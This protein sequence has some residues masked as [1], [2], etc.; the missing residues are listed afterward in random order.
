MSEPQSQGPTTGID[1]EPR[2]LGDEVA[3]DPFTVLGDW[4]PANDDPRR[5]LVQLAT[6]DADGTPHVR[7][8]LLSSWDASGFCFHT[9]ATSDKCAQ[10]AANPR[11]AMVLVQPERAHQVV[12]EGAVTRQNA[13]EAAA[14][15]R[16]RSDYLKL[17]SWLNSAELAE[18]SA[19]ERAAA[20]SALSDEAVTEPP[21]WWVGYRLAP[22]RI[23]V[24]AG[25]TTMPSRRV[26]YDRDAGGDARDGGD[27]GGSS[28]WRRRFLPG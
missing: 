12:I 6:A 28:G 18:A 22:E 23:V 9:D 15:Y 13:T 16:T 10:L 5:P 2:I 11:A 26:R 17:L 24:W 21:A 14:S 19:P 1:A 7:S 8:V 20:F 25:S 4:L 3:D 27:E